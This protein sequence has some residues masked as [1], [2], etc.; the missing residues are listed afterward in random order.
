MPIYANDV[1]E[2]KL[3]LPNGKWT[4]WSA[5]FLNK[6]KNTESESENN[7][8]DIGDLWFPNMAYGWTE[9]PSQNNLIFKNTTV[10]TNEKSGILTAADVAISN[11]KIIAV[12]KSLELKS[13]KRNHFQELD[14]T[15]KHLHV[16]S[17]M[18][19][20]ILQ[21]TEVSTKALKPVVQR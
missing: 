17:L 3:N 12:G 20:H 11:G 15:G 6:E 16:A 18:S 19:I 4:K 1:L 21:L 9:K 14:A 7:T 13:L 2:G 10:W 5:R 8:K